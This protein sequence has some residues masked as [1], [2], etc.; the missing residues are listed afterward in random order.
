MANSEATDY[1]FYLIDLI[2]MIVALIFSL[3]DAYAAETSMLIY[4][5]P[6]V[7]LS[8]AFKYIYLGYYALTRFLPLI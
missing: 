3:S 4:K 2:S 8:L 5:I 7:L 6:L 1:L